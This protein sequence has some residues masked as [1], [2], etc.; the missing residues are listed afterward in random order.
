MRRLMPEL[1]CSA[2]PQASQ[3]GSRVEPSPILDHV[4]AQHLA[5]REER[6]PGSSETNRRF[7][8]RRGSLVLAGRRDVETST[9]GS[10]START[11]HRCRAARS[12]KKSS[13][14]RAREKTVSLRASPPL[15]KPHA[16]NTPAYA[17]TTS[18]TYVKMC[19]RLQ[20]EG[21]N[22]IGVVAMMTNAYALTCQG[23]RPARECAG[24]RP[25]RAALAG[26]RTN[27]K[28]RESAG[29]RDRTF[30][31]AT[32]R[33]STARWKPNWATTSQ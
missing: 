8:V 21:S 1:L 2:L 15:A 11:S 29:S 32:R 22:E 12:Q 14:L 31:Q 19:T 30:P 9:Y 3:S 26:C 13:I 33:T 10:R 7:S 5:R 28:G 25:P 6:L 23:A 18:T 27:T 24:A 17:D 4:G 20:F 16:S